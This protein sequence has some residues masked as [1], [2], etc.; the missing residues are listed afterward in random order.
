[1]LKQYAAEK[2]A[3]VP[4]ASGAL[5]ERHARYFLGL[6]AQQ[7]SGEKPEQRLAIR[8]D[9]P[10]IRAAW[11]WAAARQDLAAL[12]PV[13]A[14]LHGFYTV[15]SWFEEGIAAFSFAANQFTDPRGAHPKQAPA[16][17]QLLMRLAR[18][19]IH[20]GRLDAARAT[21][22]QVVAV[23]PYVSDPDQ[24]STSLVYLAITHY[25]AGDYDQAAELAEESLRVSE[26]T[27]NREG[28]AF[29]LNFMGSCAKAKGDYPQAQATFERA[30]RAY[31][32]LEDGIG[33]AMAINNLGNLAQATGDYAAAQGYYQECSALFKTHDHVHGAATTLANAGRLAVRQGNYAEAR[34]MLT[35]SLELKRGINDRRGMAVALVTLGDVATKTGTY[36]EAHAQLEQALTLAEAAGDLKL[37][38]DAL[39]AVAA[40][41]LALDRR[42]AAARGV[43]YALGHKATAQESREWA[44]QVRA[45]LGGLPSEAE[46]A[47][48]RWAREDTLAEVIARM[49]GETSLE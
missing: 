10:N 7:G 8:Q 44:E 14:P 25:Y 41:A 43:A 24:H 47:A 45:E 6:L 13:I 46:A 12:A 40:L 38:L 22:A 23:L 49:L 30:V 31:Q 35:E 18:M 48:R 15:Q 2:L 32:A 20:V 1:M 26:Q 3:T 33:A 4:E 17:C 11:E 27:G 28:I 9:L 42:E 37:A 29:A 19:Q 21:L 34:T 39:V 5:A 36:A 16:T